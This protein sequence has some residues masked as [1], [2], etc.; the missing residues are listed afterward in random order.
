ML[1]ACASTCQTFQ[2]Q[3][4]APFTLFN[5]TSLLPTQ[6]MT[7][8]SLNATF[9][10]APTCV[11]FNST[12][13]APAPD[14][15]T[16]PS[17][18]IYHPQES[19]SEQTRCVGN[20]CLPCPHHFAFY[21]EKVWYYEET[22]LT[23]VRAVSCLAGLYIFL[24]YMMQPG[25]KQWTLLQMM[26]CAALW[27]ACTFFQL[28]NPSR[29][30]CVD[31]VTS[32]TMQNN[33]LCA[34]QGGLIIFA[35]MGAAVWTAYLIIN[36][37]FH[38]VWKSDVL[39]RNGVWTGL[40]LWCIPTAFTAYLVSQ[41][42]I[43]YLFGLDC[44]VTADV[45]DNL[46]FYPLSVM[47]YPAA[48]LHIV[49]F[50]IFARVVLK[51]RFNNEQTRSNTSGSFISSTKGTS[52]YRKLMVVLRTQWRAFVTAMVLV[53]IFTAFWMIHWFNTR[54]ST[55]LLT[56]S[57]AT[58][59][60]FPPWLLQWG[61]CIFTPGGT[62][63]TCRSIAEPYVPKLIPAIVSD[64][65]I[66][67]VGIVMFPVFGT[68][69]EVL[70]WWKRRQMSQHQNTVE[71]LAVGGRGGAG[72]RR[73]DTYSMRDTYGR[74]PSGGGGAGDKPRYDGGYGYYQSGG[75]EDSNYPYPPKSPVPSHQQY[76]GRAM[77]T[78]S[79]TNLLR[80]RENDDY[81]GDV[82]GYGSRDG[83]GGGAQPPPI[84]TPQSPGG[85]GGGG[86]G[87]QS[88][89]TP[90]S[91]VASRYQQQQ[92]PTRHARSPSSH[93]V[94]STHSAR[95]YRDEFDSFADA[96]P[97]PQDRYNNYSRQHQQP[98]QQIRSP[99]RG[100]P[101]PAPSHRSYASSH[102]QQTQQHWEERDAAPPMPVTGGGYGRTQ[103]GEGAIMQ[104]VGGRGRQDV[105][106]YGR[107]M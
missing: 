15:L 19:P 47:I 28:G 24:A 99:S 21:P 17:P 62:Q 105:D 106:E 49:T 93:S 52:N 10:P 6:C 88:P 67:I 64:V 38:I 59:T 41:K 92:Q 87:P 78:T 72:E 79:S 89:R 104:I 54:K 11:S 7:I 83:Y 107:R 86:Y 50:I 13:L 100:A 1:T 34:V 85:Y 73:S 76:G 51:A 42:K 60:S 39:E 53:V 44:L 26:G 94:H 63:E 31:D 74:K 32:S 46:F 23:A 61:N 82:S 80:E 2:A 4:T 48:V 25:K 84:Y 70:R 22:V 40:F 65:L 33:P 27:Q 95:T 29:V 97:L 75:E 12:L 96:P 16:C 18:L 35:S 8:P 101:S 71:S 43:A 37:H 58:P 14:T 56:F 36:L 69:P 98:Q 103:Y 57:S 66:C 91:P 20:C 9:A 5:Q 77:T 102:H 3:C 45:A 30:Q 55:S 90:T 81:F 68:R